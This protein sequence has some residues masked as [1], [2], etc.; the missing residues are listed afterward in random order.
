MGANRLFVVVN[1]LF[2]SLKYVGLANIIAYPL[3][4]FAL[5]G[6]TSV[7]EDF[8]GYR[9]EITPTSDAILAG[10][11]IGVLVPI[12]ASITPIWGVINNDLAEN[13]NPIRNKTEAT[14]IEVYVEGKEFPYGKVLF[15]IIATSYGLM[16]YYLL[17]RALI[18]QNLG[19][20]LT[21]FFIIL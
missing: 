17:P 8:F 9:H 6:V 12:V 5:E 20:L 10:L 19:L 14:K 21:I 18:N 2:S 16:I 4:Y 7:F 13:L 1:I 11:I 3:S 15:G